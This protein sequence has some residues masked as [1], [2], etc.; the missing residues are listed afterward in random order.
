MEDV[1]ANVKYVFLTDENWLW[2]NQSLAC[3]RLHHHLEAERTNNKN[4]NNGA[5]TADYSKW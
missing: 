5:T 4:N 1:F 2:F 3:R